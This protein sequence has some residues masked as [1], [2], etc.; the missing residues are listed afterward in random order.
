MNSW[1]IYNDYESEHMDF[2]T[3]AALRR[4]CKQ[5]GARLGW[6]KL[7]S[8][9]HKGFFASVY[10][11][12]SKFGNLVIDGDAKPVSDWWNDGGGE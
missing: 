11:L 12:D 3:D 6:R 4:Y 2:S 9:G 7:E 1:I 10:P 5:R 8:G